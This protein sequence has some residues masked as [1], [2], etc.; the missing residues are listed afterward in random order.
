VLN[1]INFIMP[2]D[3]ARR[4]ARIRKEHRTELAQ[5]YVEIILDLIEEDGEARLTDLAGRLGV[6]HPTVSKALRRLETEGL[7]SLRPYRAV[8]LTVQGH[9]LAVQC[10]VRHHTVAAFLVALGLDAE[11]AELEAEGI[12]HH[13]GETTLRLMS[14]FAG[15]NG[16]STA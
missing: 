5:D 10:R 6:A 14:D 11:T 4:F 9:D 3:S 1:F 16:L 2:V 7:V 13:I 8:R 12:E 15:R